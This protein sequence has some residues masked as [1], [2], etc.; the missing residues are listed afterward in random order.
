MVT[1]KEEKG[2]NRWDRRWERRW[3]RKD[4]KECTGQDIKKG[5]KKV[6]TQAVVK[7][8][9]KETICMYIYMHVQ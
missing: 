8:E 7:G 5:E 6:R 1:T 3:E 2:G 9:K 4:G